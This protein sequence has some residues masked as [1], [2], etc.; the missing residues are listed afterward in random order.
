MELKTCAGFQPFRKLRTQFARNVISGSQEKSF[1]TESLGHFSKDGFCFFCGLR[2]F[3]G[4]R[5][6]KTKKKVQKKSLLLP[7]GYLKQARA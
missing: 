3:L 5:K 1:E 2:L 4:K 7:A 6:E